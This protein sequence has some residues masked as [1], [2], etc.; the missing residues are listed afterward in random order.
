M[1]D[2]PAGELAREVV[3]E[4][5]R[6]VR[7]GFT[8]GVLDAARAALVERY[9]EF[10]RRRIERQ[11]R[12]LREARAREPAPARPSPG[13]PAAAERVVV[14][15]GPAER[16]TRVLE[17][18]RRSRRGLRIRYYCLAVVLAS[19]LLCGACFSTL[20]EYLLFGV[21]LLLG[22]G[23]H[24]DPDGPW[25]LVDELAAAREPS[26]VGALAHAAC[27]ADPRMRSRAGA[28]LRQILPALTTDDRSHIDDDAMG[29]LLRLL[30]SSHANTDLRLA[31]LQSLRHVG[32]ARAMPLVEGLAR[33]AAPGIAAG[34][35]EARIHR[36]ELAE[37]ATA[38]RAAAM[39]CLP[40]LERQAEADRQQGRLLRPAAD[41]TDDTLLR[42]APGAP[43]APEEQL[44][45]PI[46]SDDG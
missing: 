41:P 17:A 45:R 24:A 36:R 40:Y 20:A 3:E 38:L 6:L 31:I 28:G 5:R 30:G 42:P 7:S 33:N 19:A 29:A 2:D 4:Q 43:G 44:L 11:T 21:A 16:L 9:E 13:L 23:I 25:P 18:Y 12:V 27:E 22:V 39:E 35:L 10:M 37:R 8:R 14:D 26:A 1:P 32:G 34:E 46:E 15:E